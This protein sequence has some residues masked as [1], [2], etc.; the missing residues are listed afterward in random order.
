V[1]IVAAPDLI[2]CEGESTT[3][4]VPAVAGNTYVWTNGATGNSIT[5]ST[6]GMYGL[7]I[8]SPDGCATV[9][10]PVEVQ[11]IPLPDAS[12]F[13]NPFICDSGST[14]LTA[15]A[16]GGHTYEWFNVTTGA[17]V[18]TREYTVNYF[19]NPPEQDIILTV[20]NAFGCKSEAAITV[21]Q[22]PSPA[23][24]LAITGGECEGDGSTIT[25]TN[26]EPG[27]V[28]SWNTGETGLSIFTYQSGAYT[29]LATDTDSGCTGSATA[30]INP[31]PD[32]C[33]VPVGCYES[34]D[35]DTLYAPLG[36]YAYE[37][38]DQ[39]G[40]LGDFDDSTVVSV[41]GVYHVVVTDLATG[42]VATSDPLD[43]EVINCD[44]TSCDDLVTRLLRMQNLR[45]AMST[46]LWATPARPIRSPWNLPSMRP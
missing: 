1:D 35:P 31:L 36:N 25:V 42:C 12:W 6:P 26:P 15:A 13:G 34:C 23:P 17:T 21:K 9:I 33:I 8:T 11:V 14:T 2:I 29:V 27:V 18:I 5:V 10:D 20:T 4:S 45:P 22:V 40:S 28:Y 37:W 41:S 19:F 38:F 43:L 46:L 30:V 16:G 32:L 3:L 39:D 24:V 7:L 44:S